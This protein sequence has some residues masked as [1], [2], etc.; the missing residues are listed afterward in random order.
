M[1]KSEKILC[2]VYGAIAVVA[3]VATWTNNLAFF[4][5]PEN[6]QV[7]SFLHALYL[8]HASASIANDLFLLCL[9]CFIFMAMEARKLGIRYVWVYILLS[10]LVA[11]SVMFP[12]FLVARQVA[13]SKQRTR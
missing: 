1:T 12:L 7:T 5:Q 6:H 11:I 10:M 4:A 13:L 8:N 9:A 2:A 3:L